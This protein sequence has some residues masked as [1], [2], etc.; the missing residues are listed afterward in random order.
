M[1]YLKRKYE[2]KKR[3]KKNLE[4]RL[5]REKEGE[6][7][8]DVCRFLTCWSRTFSINSEAAHL[9]VMMKSLL[10]GSTVRVTVVEKEKV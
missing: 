6:D 9:T 7:K 4:K 10:H 1:K 3:N 5:A 2:R 8:D